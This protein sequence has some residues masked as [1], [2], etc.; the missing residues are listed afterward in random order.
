[1][2]LLCEQLFSDT[3]SL[4]RLNRLSAQ[5]GAGAG[6]GSELGPLPGT[7]WALLLSLA[8]AWLLILLYLLLSRLK[9]KKR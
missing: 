7:A 1:M 9:K 8:A 5:N 4:Y 2:K 6:D 3:T